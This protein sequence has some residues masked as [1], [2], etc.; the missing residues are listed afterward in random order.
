MGAGLAEHLDITAGDLVE[1]LDPVVAAGAHEAFHVG[2][3]P[4]EAGES[5]VFAGPVE[6]P[7]S[8]G[9]HIPANDVQFNCG[10]TFYKQRP[11]EPGRLAV[12]VVIAIAD[13]DAAG[14]AEGGVYDN[15]LV[16]H[17]SAE[18]E[19]AA[20][21]QGPEPAKVNAGGFPFADDLVGEV[22]GRVAVEEN[23][24]PD[25]PCGGA[26]QRGRDELAGLVAVKDISLEMDGVRCFVDQLHQ[27]RE[28]VG[29]AVD[30]T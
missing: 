7:V 20:L 17:A 5:V 28:V 29:A 26:E 27:R 3:D 16:M 23:E 14:H 24:D 22:L 21:E 9:P 12:N 2:R 13:I 15:Y 1:A 8:L 4:G 11:V 18:V 6:I 30:E 10:L 25:L 19:V